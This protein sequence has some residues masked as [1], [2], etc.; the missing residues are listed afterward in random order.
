MQS[1]LARLASHISRDRG[2]LGGKEERKKNEAFS[3][4]GFHE[5]SLLC[6]PILSCSWMY[7]IATL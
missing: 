3:V 2:F 4:W 6:L 1:A 5:N 7:V